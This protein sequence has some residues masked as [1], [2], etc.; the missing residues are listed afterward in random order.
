MNP[1]Y[2]SYTT[3]N[4]TK[5]LLF[6]EHAK[7]KKKSKEKASRGVLIKN[8]NA[9][10]SEKGS[11]F[12]TPQSKSSSCRSKNN[13]KSKTKGNTSIANN[14]LLLKM[15]KYK[16]YQP[17]LKSRQNTTKKINNTAIGNECSAKNTMKFFPDKID[18]KIGISEDIFK[19]ENILLTEYPKENKLLFTPNVLKEKFSYDEWNKLKVNHESFNS[20]QSARNNKAEKGSLTIHSENPLQRKKNKHYFN[21]SLKKNSAISHNTYN[22]NQPFGNSSNYSSLSLTTPFNSKS[23]GI[24]FSNENTSTTAATNYS[25]H[26]QINSTILKYMKILFGDHLENF[27]ENGM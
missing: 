8:R 3:K 11:A 19:D 10:S 27:D 26:L 5:A 1:K 6:Q 16:K 24:N 23:S 17:P 20:S 2:T 13:S 15:S 12:I 4:S 18:E 9:F 14:D 22:M 25:N 21:S 7:P